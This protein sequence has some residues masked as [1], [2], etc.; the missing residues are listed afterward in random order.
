MTSAMPTGLV[1]TADDG[2]WWYPCERDMIAFHLERHH[3]EHP[4]H[5]AC[6]D[7]LAVFGEVCE[8]ITNVDVY[9]RQR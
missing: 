4:H 3:S 1:V 5:K 7:F 2:R 6:K 9:A 8:H